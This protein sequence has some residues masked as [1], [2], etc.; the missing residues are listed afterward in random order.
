MAVQAHFT[1]SDL[2]DESRYLKQIN[3][4]A[5]LVIDDSTGVTLKM[6]QD[7]GDAVDPDN[8]AR[9]EKAKRQRNELR[10]KA[11]EFCCTTDKW[12]TVTWTMQV[13]INE[14]GDWCATGDQFYHIVQVK[15]VGVD[16][17]FFTIGI[18]D[19]CISVHKCDGHEP[20]YVCCMPVDNTIGKWFDVHVS[21]DIPA[22]KIHYM[23]GSKP[24]AGSYTCTFPSKPTELYL[25]VGLYRSWPNNAKRTASVSYRNIF[26]C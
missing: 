22:K 1:Q 4:D 24:Y 7:D 17:P 16:R 15:G 14:C 23:V 2:C 19:G 26:K 12:C 13:R 6:T 25:K 10:F 5:R 20:T 9:K 3:C 8:I 18:K 21:V 11:K